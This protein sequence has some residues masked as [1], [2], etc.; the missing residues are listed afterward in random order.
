M[1]FF[2]EQQVFGIFWLKDQQILL[3]FCPHIPYWKCYPQKI[4]GYV[5]VFPDFCKIFKNTYLE[6]TCKP[7]LLIFEVHW[8][9]CN[10][11]TIHLCQSLFFDNIARWRPVTLLKKRSQESVF[12]W[13]F[14]NLK[15]LSKQI[16]SKSETNLRP[17]WNEF[18]VNV[19][20]IRSK[21]VQIWSKCK[22]N[23]SAIWNKL[24]AREQKEKQIAANS[25][26]I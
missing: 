15:W 22:T 9:F 20:Q 7:L 5:P 11:Y 14:W 21:F 1:F 12:T 25:L 19:R 10:I 16:W 26:V 8:K 2:F 23:L 4:S 3:G 13:C 24:K 18:E 17:V 6:N